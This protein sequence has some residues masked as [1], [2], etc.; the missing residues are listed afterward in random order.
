MCAVMPCL[1]I[2]AAPCIVLLLLRVVSPP[3]SLCVCC[4][5]I[6]GLGL[7]FCGG[8][9][10]LWNGG[11]DLCVGWNGGVC[12]CVWSLR[13]LLAF[14]LFLF[15]FLFVL[16]FG[17]VRAQPCEHARYP[18]TPLCLRL[19]LLSSLVLSLLFSFLHSPSFCVWNGGG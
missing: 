16:V 13:C 5:S 3:S 4:H 11:V 7:C 8:V 15:L 9:M 1:R 19:L 10:S 18:R 2:G 17:V 12:S 14:L 6:V